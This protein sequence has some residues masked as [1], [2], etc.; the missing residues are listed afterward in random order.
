MELYFIHALVL[1][2][3]ESSLTPLDWDT[4][5]A[6][7]YAVHALYCTTL[8]RLFFHSDNQK[9]NCA[10]DIS[11]IKQTIENLGNRAVY[12]QQIIIL[13]DDENEYDAQDVLKHFNS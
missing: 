12:E 8:S 7:D 4:V 5:I 9:T 2:P 6:Q 13:R 11:L 10:N 3:F 1:T